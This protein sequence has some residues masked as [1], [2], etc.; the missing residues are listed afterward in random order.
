M[1]IK[2]KIIAMM[3]TFVVVGSLVG[4]GQSDTQQAPETEVVTPE[5]NPGEELEQDTVDTATSELGNLV[6]TI[7]EGVEL[8]NQI[9]ML[10][11][12][13]ADTYGIDT[14]LLK[15][16][17]VSISMMN[18]QAT[19]IAIFE[20]KDEKDADIVMEGI[21]KRQ[22]GL[23]EQWSSYLPEQYELVKNYKVEQKGNKILFVISEQA[24]KIVDN[25]NNADK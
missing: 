2:R 12:M 24:D 21:E 20:L 19:E 5:D 15:D 13:F 23:E 17:Y 3:M 6:E 14:N 7:T 1:K 9:A 8:P 18:V 22:K 10:P 11:E 4:C 25:F 16:Y